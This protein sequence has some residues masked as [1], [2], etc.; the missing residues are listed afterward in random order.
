MNTS[1]RKLKSLLSRF[2]SAADNFVENIELLRARGQTD[3]FEIR[4]LCRSYAVDMISKYVFAVDVDSFKADQ[5]N[6]EFAKLALRVGDLN[7]LGIL[8]I[9]FIPK[10]MWKLL[11]LNIF[12]VEPINKL[13]DLFKKKIR[14]RDP[15]VRFN[16]LV[17]LF[18]EQIRDGK[19][20]DM[21][22]DEIIANCLV[23]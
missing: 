21:T 22:E 10:F 3:V 2:E 9:N 16:D 1:S 17:E 12:D 6:S 13:G 15:S 14:E 19:L 4:K 23:F 20:K 5:Q 8:L 18:R 7:I 11:N